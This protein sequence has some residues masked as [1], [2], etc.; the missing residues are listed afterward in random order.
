MHFFLKRYVCQL[1]VVPKLANISHCYVFLKQIIDGNRYLAI[2]WPSWQTWF[3]TKKLANIL[4]AVG[5]L[6]TQ[7]FKCSQVQN[8][9]ISKTTNDRLL[10][11]FISIL[12][13][14]SHSHVPADCL[15]LFFIA[16]YS[17][18]L[19]RNFCHTSDGEGGPR[20]VLSITQYIIQF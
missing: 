10:F 3:K 8:V 17:L 14:I 9:N 16:V 11:Y 13:T 6:T 7:K 5:G 12:N 4:P 18:V 2:R 20:F 1:C 19:A 15:L